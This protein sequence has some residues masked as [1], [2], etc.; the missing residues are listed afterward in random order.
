MC[1]KLPDSQVLAQYLP[2]ADGEQRTISR[3]AVDIFFCVLSRCLLMLQ[4]VRLPPAIIVVVTLNSILRTSK[5]KD[6]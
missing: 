5:A 3:D 4:R 6:T 2:E 1:A